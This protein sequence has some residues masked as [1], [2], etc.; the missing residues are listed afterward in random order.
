VEGVMRE[1]SMKILGWRPYALATL[2]TSFFA[3]GTYGAWTLNGL[4]LETLGVTAVFLLNLHGLVRLVYAGPKWLYRVDDRC[5]V[6]PNSGFSL[7][8]HQ[9]RVHGPGSLEVSG[10]SYMGI[11]LDEFGKR[12]C[13]M[14]LFVLRTDCESFLHR[15]RVPT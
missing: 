9:V 2:M 8:S 14:G 15:I 13:S 4:T 3:V 5:L 6:V 12:V 7:H 11:R 1:Q 10:N